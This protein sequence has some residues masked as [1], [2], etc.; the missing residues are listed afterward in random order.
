MHNYKVYHF[1][2]QDVID[3]HIVWLD[4]PVNKSLVMHVG[5][6]IGNLLAPFHLLCVGYDDSPPQ[7]LIH[8]AANRSVFRQL[9]HNRRH[10]LSYIII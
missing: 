4:V 6:C 5:D 8:D 9:K 2:V 7:L 1:Y 3:Q 10:R